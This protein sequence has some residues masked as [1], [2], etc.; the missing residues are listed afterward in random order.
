MPARGRV[1]AGVACLF[2]LA[3]AAGDEDGERSRRRDG[4]SQGARPPRV[5]VGG[6]G[7]ARGGAATVTS[8]GGEQKCAVPQRWSL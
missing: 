1:S 6:G 3:E 2:A 4:E 8:L 7:P 5:A